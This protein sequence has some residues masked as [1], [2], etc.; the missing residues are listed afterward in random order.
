MKEQNITA[1][2]NY[3]TFVPGKFER[4]MNFSASPPLGKTVPDFPLWHLDTRPTTLI[5]VLSQSV[6]TVVEF[7]SF[8]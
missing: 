3:D 2:Y 5:Q 8:T 4:W 6:L 7:G 1:L